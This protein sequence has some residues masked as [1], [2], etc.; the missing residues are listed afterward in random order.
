MDRLQS[1]R[2]FLAVVDAGSLSAAGRR[3]G[4]PLATVSRKVSDLE[5][6][7]KTQLLIRSTRQLTLT[8]SGRG[9]TEACRRVLE[10]VDEAERAAAGEYS[11]PRGELVVTAP[12]LFGRLQVLPVLTEF[13]RAYPNVTVRLALGDRILNLFEDH[14]DL[15]IRIGE[16]PDSGLVATRLGS[17]R[18]IVCAS[19]EYLSRK[20]TPQQVH[21][22]TAHDCISFEPFAL[23]NTWRFEVDDVEVAVPIHPRLTVST[24]EA[25]IDAAVSGSGVTS[26]LC[27]QAESSLRNGQ[28]ALLLESFELP[29]IPVSFVYANQGR[30]PLKLRALLDFAAPRLRTRLQE[31]SSVLSAAAEQK[32]RRRAAKPN[33]SAL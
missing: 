6:A 8:E 26:V 11:E 25:A 12:V 17:I 10:D 33:K 28:L 7:L 13:L 31:V 15:A 21:D 14:V 20:G 27:Y 24:A 9:Y 1:M 18:R 22:L 4:M 32:S 23:G 19:P 29:S 30:L 5:A 2:V 16:L 3:L